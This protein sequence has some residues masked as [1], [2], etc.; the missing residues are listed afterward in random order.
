MLWA[1]RGYIHEFFIGKAFRPFYFWGFVGEHEVDVNEACD[2]ANVTQ[3]QT[4]MSSSD[5]LIGMITLFI[6]APRTAKVWCE[7]E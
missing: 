6:Y 1:H 7:E 5:Y 3:M 2:G 4:V